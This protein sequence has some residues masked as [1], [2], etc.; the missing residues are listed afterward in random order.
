[1]VTMNYV[2]WI[3]YNI[4]PI[5]HNYQIG[6]FTNN[7]IE[8][9]TLEFCAYYT[10][11]KHDQEKMWIPITILNFYL[12]C[13]V[14][15]YHCIL[16]LYLSLAV[17]QIVGHL[18][19]LKHS[20]TSIPRP[21]NKTFI[22]VY[23]MPVAV[24]MFD[25]EENKQVYKDISECIS[26]HCMI[27]RFTDEVSVLFG[28]TIAISYL[29]HLFGCCLSLL[30]VLS[31]DYKALTHYGVFTFA[32]F[33]QLCHISILFE[34]LGAT[35][36]KLI[37][38]VYAVPWECMDV[39]NRRAVL[40]LLRRVQTPIRISALGL[41]DVGV[42]TML[43]ISNE[44]N[45]LIATE[46]PR[47]EQKALSIGDHAE[48]TLGLIWKTKN[49][50]LSFSL[51]STNCPREV[52]QEYRSP[53]KREVTSVVIGSTCF[54]EPITVS[55]SF[56]PYVAHRLTKIED[57]SSAKN[58]RWVLSKDNIADDATR[59]P[60]NEFSSEYR[61]FKGPKF[62]LNDPSNCLANR[63]NTIDQLEEIIELKARKV[64]VQ[65]AQRDNF[66]V[67]PRCIKKR[68]PMPKKSKLRN[69]CVE[70][71]KDDAIRATGRLD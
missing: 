38:A 43:G 41:A 31:G 8:N 6:A 23:D 25:D 10:I 51:N 40:M 54:A 63:I 27:I 49:D 28:P 71:D 13:A 5:Y 60:S 37:D 44:P 35:S 16:D 9:S 24:E 64:I 11:P 33:G 17:F 1:M 21:K 55:R 36:E 67:E 30:Q 46:S 45:A 52:I 56:K 12:T 53:T 4:P 19:I 14:A 42:Q 7:R 50:T 62:L 65:K 3:V 20:L 59:D 48:R 69:M 26:H 22:E 34:V 18:Y 15:S 32:I 2:A 39:P 29:F 58:W 47:K 68:K 66:G 57:T 70:L 61:R